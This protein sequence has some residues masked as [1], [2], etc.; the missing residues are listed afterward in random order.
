MGLWQKGDLFEGSARVPLVV[1]APG[2]SPGAHTGAV[3]EMVDIY[4]H[5]GRVVRFVP[6]GPCARPEPS[7][8][9]SSAE[10]SGQGCGFDGG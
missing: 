1:A 7:T 6:A 9:A 3:T 10:P 5:V 8:C 4:P 2:V